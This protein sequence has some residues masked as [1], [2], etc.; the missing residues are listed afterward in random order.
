MASL[1]LPN[2]FLEAF[3]SDQLFT[4][5]SPFHTAEA[6]LMAKV[7]ESGISHSCILILHLIFWSVYFDFGV[8]YLV[9]EN[10][11]LQTS[12]HGSIFHWPNGRGL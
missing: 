9:F 4:S 7:E 12:L 11:P 5:S 6:A 3:P 10:Q 1:I 8:V 2:F